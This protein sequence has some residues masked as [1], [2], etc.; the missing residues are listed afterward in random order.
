M[1]LLV[2]ENENAQAEKRLYRSRDKRSSTKAKCL[3]QYDRDAFLL[4]NN[5]PKRRI[6]PSTRYKQ[7]TLLF[8]NNNRGNKFMELPQQTPEKIQPDYIQGW[9]S[10]LMDKY[11]GQ[12]DG[13]GFISGKLN[14]YLYQEPLATM[15]DICQ[16]SPV[17]VGVMEAFGDTFHNYKRVIYAMAAS[18][19]MQRYSEM[20]AAQPEED[21]E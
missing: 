15:V 6:S 19:I 17:G 9:A 14:D 18:L 16:S 12:D 3:Y 11:N 7:R 2:T 1:F 13:G 8:G 4:A 10:W 20:L 21:W 5:T